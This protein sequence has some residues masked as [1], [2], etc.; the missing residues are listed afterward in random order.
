M[1]LNNIYLQIWW[2][3]THAREVSQELSHCVIESCVLTLIFHRGVKLKLDNYYNYFNISP[4]QYTSKG[5]IFSIF[6]LKLS[7]LDVN[8]LFYTTIIDSCQSVSLY[9]HIHCH[10]LKHI[11]NKFTQWNKYLFNA[12]FWLKKK[13]RFGHHKLQS[14]SA[15][16]IFSVFSM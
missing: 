14:S 16:C 11:E 4:I 15:T 6:F 2:I 7:Q 12:H 5:R 10:V 1:K 13:Y 3:T 9:P 8:S